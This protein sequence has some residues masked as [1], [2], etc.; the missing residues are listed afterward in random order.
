[1]AIIIRSKRMLFQGM[2]KGTL[3]RP[4]HSCLNSEIASDWSQITVDSR[5]T[6]LPTFLMDFG[7]F[8]PS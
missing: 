7:E 3:I 6:P 8:P 4:E 2:S 5:R 1:M